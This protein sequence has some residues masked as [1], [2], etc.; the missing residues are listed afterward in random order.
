MKTTVVAAVFLLSF[1]VVTSAYFREKKLRMCGDDLLWA[2]EVTCK[3]TWQ[4]ML[5]PNPNEG[6]YDY[7]DNDYRRELKQEDAGSRRVA[8]KTRGKKPGQWKK[9]TGILTKWFQTERICCLNGCTRHTL[10]RACV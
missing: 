10:M 1:I 8:R 2:L 3:R 6:D 5:E 7:F 9:L 4:R